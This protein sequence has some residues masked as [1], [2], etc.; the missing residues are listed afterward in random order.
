MNRMG[1]HSPPV[2]GVVTNGHAPSL[3]PFTISP[4]LQVRQGGPMAPWPAQHANNDSRGD[5]PDKTERWRH[6]AVEH[7][8]WLAAIPVILVN[9]VAVIAQLAFLRAHMSWAP[10]GKALVAVTLE[11][12]AVYLAWQ[13]HLAIVADD[14]AMR[15]RLAAYGF[16]AIVGVMNY[17]H[18]MAPGWRPTFPALVFALCSVMSPWLW[19]IHSRRESRDTLKTRG[20]IEPHA[21]RLGATRWIWHPIRSWRVMF[22]ATW[23]GEND[24]VRAIALPA[25][26]APVVAQ[27]DDS[28]S[29]AGDDSDTPQPPS[30]DDKDDD[31]P[32]P[33]DSD[34]M[35]DAPPPPPP[36]PNPPNNRRKP[37]TGRDKVLAIMKRNPGLTDAE[38][39]K[40]AGVSVRTVQRARA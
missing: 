4:E 7:R 10:A 26:K 14:S 37:P 5:T 28:D 17:S 30:E 31:T 16:A 24:P 33:P 39:A 36:P 29:D 25:M 3:V 20:L 34:R 35:D 15:L 21:V 32:P 12:V 13:A 1:R 22:R 18:Y 2:N 38:V 19:S 11:S 40:R 27:D 6:F 9:A 8:G 23:K